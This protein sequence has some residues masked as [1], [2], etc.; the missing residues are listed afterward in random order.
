MLPG[1]A[2]SGA[3]EASS[4]ASRIQSAKVIGEIVIRSVL[5]CA[6]VKIAIVPGDGIGVDVTKEAVKVLEA[7]ERR[8]PFGFD[9]V[10]FLWSADHY[11]KTGETVP[12]GAFEDFSRNYAAIFMGA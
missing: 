10:S 6:A 3:R 4:R 7:V 2:R 5:H 12:A 1:V 9:P 8:R 11:L